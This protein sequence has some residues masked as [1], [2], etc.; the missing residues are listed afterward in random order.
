MDDKLW[1]SLRTIL[2][3]RAD[4]LKLK[5]DISIESG[6]IIL[7]PPV[8]PPG[9]FY[10]G[11]VIV[12][13]FVKD[14]TVTLPFHI[15][16]GELN[17]HVLIVGETGM[18]KTNLNY[19]LLSQ[20]LKQD[21]PCL[22]IDVKQDYRHLLSQFENLVVIPWQH[23]R[24]NP[25]SL[26]AS[27]FC[28]VFCQ[29]SSLLLGSKGFLLEAVITLQNQLEKHPMPAE[30]LKYLH[31]VK[32]HPMSRDSQY[33][34]VVKNRIK[35]L[36]LELGPVVNCQEG[37]PIEDILTRNIV[38]EL[39]GLGKEMQDFL[40]NALLRRIFL[41]RMQQNQRGELRHLI[42]F[43]EAKRVFDVNKERRPVEGIP[44]ISILSSQVREFGEGLV[45]ADQEPSKLTDSIKA[46]TNCKIVF[47]LGQGR[48]IRD[49][50]LTICLDQQGFFSRLKVGEAIVKIGN[51]DPFLLRIPLQ[52]IQKTV[53]QE[54]IEARFKRFLQEQ[55]R[56]KPA[57]VI[58][59]PKIPQVIPY[60]S[61]PILRPEQLKPWELKLLLD[62]AQFSYRTIVQRRKKLGLTAGSFHKIKTNLIDRGLITD[63]PLNV[64]KFSR[65]NLL[66]LTAQGKSIAQQRGI[67]IKNESP[68]HQY[69]VH[70][71][72]K[73]YEGQGYTV[74]EEYHRI[75]LV[76]F[77]GKEIIAN[78]IETGKSDWKKNIQKLLRL[79]CT[80]RRVWATNQQVFQRIEKEC[81][82]VEVIFCLDFFAT[83]NASVARI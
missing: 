80:K 45:V 29:D 25:L 44:T 63:Y 33:L 76:A 81:P 42:F 58:S 32:L 41:Y 4:L 43:D 55:G 7:K 75:D 38:L 64:G 54:E 69:W 35:T 13:D 79:D 48:D 65:I 3:D 47:H 72:K 82:K 59:T 67:L 9:E 83:T 78:E 50:A 8:R 51:H 24:F 71:I 40:I 39:D 16:R 30:L 36:L 73:W 68:E 27:E 11:E 17:K 62:I 56:K 6:K 21:I 15:T 5:Y 57:S 61:Y 74:K 22:I 26:P 18:G 66:E 60:I 19:L 53:T 37:F 34:G 14:T 49:S 20:V 70:R 46:N 23:F 52:H 1:R 2:G 77:K 28:D 10:L 12:E 31:R